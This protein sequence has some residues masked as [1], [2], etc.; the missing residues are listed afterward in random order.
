[1]QTKKTNMLKLKLQ[2]FAEEPGDNAQTSEGQEKQDTPEKVYSEEEFNQRLNSELQRRLKQ[3]ED[4]KAEAVK[5]AQK[6][7]K[8][9]KDQQLQYEN[10]KLTK[11]LEEYKVRDAKSQMKA[12]ARLMLNKEGIDVTEEP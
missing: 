7:A 10:E 3:K 8:M 1:M 6:L 12:E 4:E 5:E 2:F 9:N 11:Q